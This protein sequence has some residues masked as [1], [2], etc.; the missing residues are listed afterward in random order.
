MFCCLVSEISI[1]V[2]LVNKFL[3]LF[4]IVQHKCPRTAFDLCY[5]VTVSA[6]E[7]LL[8]L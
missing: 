7:Y 2:L 3:Y 1:K 6:T 4:G 5:E 8:L